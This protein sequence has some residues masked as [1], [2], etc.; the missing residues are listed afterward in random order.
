MDL[1]L[2]ER[3]RGV[4]Q[5]ERAAEGLADVAASSSAPDALGAGGRLPIATPSWRLDPDTVLP[6]SPAA[7]AP[8]GAVTRATG[9]DI[10]LVLAFGV[11]GS[12]GTGG[13]IGQLRAGIP[14]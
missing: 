4:R 8:V 9:G 11:A 12:T 10:P 1:A 6:E 13:G 3:Q 7:D 5:R 14:A 2:P